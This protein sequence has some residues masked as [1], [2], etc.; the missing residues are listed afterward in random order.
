MEFRH[1]HGRRYHAFKDGTYLMPNDDEELQ[2][3]G[4]LKRFQT[5]LH[6]Y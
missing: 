6:P 5:V 4:V 1:E 3:L 2:R